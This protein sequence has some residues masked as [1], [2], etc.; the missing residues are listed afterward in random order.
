MN[1]WNIS[2]LL[3]RFVNFSKFIKNFLVSL[4]ILFSGKIQDYT[5]VKF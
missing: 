2:F 1:K 5:T 3:N 4:K